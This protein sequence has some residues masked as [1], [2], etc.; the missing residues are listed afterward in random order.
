MHAPLTVRPA[1]LTAVLVILAAP[2]LHA[3]PLAWVLNTNQ[4]LDLV[5]VPTN[6]DVPLSTLPFQSDSLAASPTGALYSADGFGN[7]WDVTG[8]PIP[9]GPT[10]RTQIA[11]LDWDA[12]GLWGY[13]N[14]SKELFY[15]DLGSSS[16]T[17]AAT[18]TLPGSLSPTA[19][20]AGV[21]HDASTGDTYLSAWDGLN[22]DFLLRVASSST[23]ALLVGAMAQ[24]DGASYIADID[25]DAAGTLYAVTWYHRWFYSVSPTTAATTFVSAGPHR[26]TTA[27]AL[28][29]VPVPAAAW[30]FGGALAALPGLRRRRS[31]PPEGR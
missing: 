10:L 2:P 26:D 30:L 17:Y 14:A 5:N 28:K 18:L 31:G 8:A 25:F 23:T 4:T 19:V 6:A 21:A 9:V 20:V 16:V 7:L 12:N 22:N 24:S 27:M 11:D 15:F 29:P 3:A 13:S 1:A